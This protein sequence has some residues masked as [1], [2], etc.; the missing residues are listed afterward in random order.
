MADAV[1]GWSAFEHWDPAR[2]QTIRLPAAQIPRIGYIPIAISKFTKNKEAAG[3]S[4]ETRCLGSAETVTIYKHFY[5]GE[6]EQSGR[7]RKEIGQIL[8][9]NSGKAAIGQVVDSSLSWER[10]RPIPVSPEFRSCLRFWRR[11]DKPLLNS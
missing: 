6:H 7:R 1:T 8:W 10:P 4:V 9:R 5:P 11:S 2:I 3:I